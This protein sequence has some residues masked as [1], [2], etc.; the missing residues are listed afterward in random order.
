MIWNLIGCLFYFLSLERI[1]RWK[2]G[3][4]GALRVSTLCRICIAEIKTPEW[5]AYSRRKLGRQKWQELR[6][7]F[8]R[9]SVRMRVCVYVSNSISKITKN[10]CGLVFGNVEI[11]GFFAMLELSPVA[12]NSRSTS[13]SIHTDEI[14]RYFGAFSPPALFLLLSEG[15]CFFD[16]RLSLAGLDVDGYGSDVAASSHKRIIGGTRKLVGRMR[17]CWRFDRLKKLKPFEAFFDFSLSPFPPPSPS[18]SATN[19]QTSCEHSSS[20]SRSAFQRCEFRDMRG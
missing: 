8:E 12:R 20:F 13:P 3:G 14:L 1:D 11:L 16:V 10:V 15:K 2:V 7:A 6:E 9:K 5:R 17:N 18:L 19:C 4:G